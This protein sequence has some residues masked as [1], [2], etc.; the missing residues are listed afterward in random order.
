ML[1][2]YLLAVTEFFSPYL[3]RK[4]RLLDNYF[5]KERTEQQINTIQRLQQKQWEEWE[6]SRSGIQWG[7]VL[8][9]EPAKWKNCG[10]LGTINS[11][12]RRRKTKKTTEDA[13]FVLAKWDYFC[14][15]QLCN[16]DGDSSSFV[17]L[18]YLP[19]C[20]LFAVI[21]HCFLLIVIYVICICWKLTH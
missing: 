8:K 19:F 14:F 20:S 18:Y 21:Y 6:K 3:Q 17:I 13:R 1:K 2:T 4:P 5:Q 10:S 9:D 11:R 7:R 15:H 16:R 12:S